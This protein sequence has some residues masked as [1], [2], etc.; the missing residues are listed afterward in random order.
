MF[1]AH[2]MIGVY[3]ASCIDSRDPRNLFRFYCEE[4]LRRL[5]VFILDL[6]RSFFTTEARVPGRLNKKQFCV[7]CCYFK[8]LLCYD[9]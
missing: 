9:N 5:R 7:F 4:S 8:I 1:M 2:V 6:L 3:R